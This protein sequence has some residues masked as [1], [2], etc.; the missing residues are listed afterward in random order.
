MAVVGLSVGES[1]AALFQCRINAFA[2]AGCRAVDKY[3]A[4]GSYVTC[5]AAVTAKEG[6]VLLS[7]IHSHRA[8]SN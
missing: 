3:L 1:S 5:Y 2:D 7:A 4:A 6:N 8:T